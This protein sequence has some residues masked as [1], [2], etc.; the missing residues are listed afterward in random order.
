MFYS[1]AIVYV[2]LRRIRRGIAGADRA[3]RGHRT[4]CFPG[5]IE[6]GFMLGEI[7]IPD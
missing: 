2:F 3:N 6:R 7:P 1:V 5:A 4:K